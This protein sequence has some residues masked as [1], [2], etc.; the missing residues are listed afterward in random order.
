MPSRASSEANSRADSCCMSVRTGGEGAAHGLGRQ[1]FGLGQ[2]L[3]G[4]EPQLVGDGADGGVELYGV[5]DVGGEQSDL[6]GHVRA[7]RLAGQ[8]VAR[9]RARRVSRPSVVSEMI[10]GRQPE[11][12]LGEGERGRRARHCDVAGADDAEPAGAHRAVDAGDHRLGQLDDRL[13]QREHALRAGLRAA[14]ARLLLE[15]RAGAEHPA[16]VGEHDR[17]HVAVVRRRRPGER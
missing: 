17:A 4:A 10:A 11:A 7:E 8:V 14:L 15:V 16:G 2:P 12:D 6:R 5:L 13:H 9:G 1:R 3:R